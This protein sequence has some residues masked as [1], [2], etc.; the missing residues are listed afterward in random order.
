MK[1]INLFVT[2]FDI[3][4]KHP[5]KAQF[6]FPVIN[7]FPVISV[8]VP[9]SQINNRFKQLLDMFSMRMNYRFSFKTTTE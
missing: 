8:S 9:I 3:Y 4:P 6:A 2:V 1:T 7:E 5:K